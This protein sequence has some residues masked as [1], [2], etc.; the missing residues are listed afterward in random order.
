M[1]SQT[2]LA[3]LQGETELGSH[4]YLRVLS[5]KY[6]IA[7]LNA[8]LTRLHVPNTN[9]CSLH[10]LEAVIRERGLTIRDSKCERL[11]HLL[12]GVSSWEEVGHDTVKIRIHRYERHLAKLDIPNVFRIIATVELTPSDILKSDS[13]M[14]S[15]YD[16]TITRAPN[17]EGDVT[18]RTES[19]EAQ[20]HSRYVYEDSAVFDS[21][22]TIQIYRPAVVFQFEESEINDL[23]EVSR[24]VERELTWV[25]VA[26]SLCYR[27]RVTWY[28]LSFQ[29]VQENG[30]PLV[31]LSP[32]VR[33]RISEKPNTGKVNELINHFNLVNGGFEELLNQLRE[34]CLSDCIVRSIRFLSASTDNN[35]VEMNYLLVIAALECFCNG[36]LS[37]SGK[38]MEIPSKFAK[39][40]KNALSKTINELRNDEIPAEWLDIAKS[41]LPE[42]KRPTT[43]SSIQCCC[44]E[45]RVTFGDLWNVREPSDGLKLALK[46]RNHLVHQANSASP[47]EL[48]PDTVRLRIL[49]E[50]LILS[51]IGWD[52]D[53]LSIWHAEELLRI[54]QS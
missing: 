7:K 23:S 16:G 9:P 44:Q 2:T 52:L 45:L 24:I 18:W 30:T 31:G 26:L 3:E 1:E 17:Y 6:D 47:R 49:A 54:R 13:S 4:V 34:S 37:Q 8:F 32:L 20:L 53:K 27:K 41:K 50:R 35:Y 12:Q 19:A 29:V 36:Y 43:F 38:Q 10:Q 11:S 39:K 33:R 48:Y 40:I 42:L 5:D 21:K 28:K 15:S 14:S 25:C 22:A 46:N 51:F